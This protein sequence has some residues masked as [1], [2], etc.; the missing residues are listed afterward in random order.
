MN[1]SKIAY[2]SPFPLL[3]AHVQQSNTRV[4]SIA[5][6]CTSESLLPTVSA[7]SSVDMP[8]SST[9]VSLLTLHCTI[10]A[11]MYLNVHLH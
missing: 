11:C 1:H 6:V 4:I 9:I 5:C 8:N 3:L 2:T 7:L 10:A